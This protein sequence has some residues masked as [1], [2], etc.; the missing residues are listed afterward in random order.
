MDDLQTSEETTFVQD[1]VKNIVKESIEGI[2]GSSSYSH[3]KVQ[4]WTSS[5]I[6][7]CLSQLTKLG[8][9]FKYIVTCV[10][11][12][13]SGAGLHTASSCYWDSTTDGSCTVKWENKS[14]Y[15]IVTVFGLAI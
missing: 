7:Q 2:I 3:N 6:E 15:F 11:M 13:K 14:M 9:P 10:I 12:Q 5:V 4:Q 8:K 1:E